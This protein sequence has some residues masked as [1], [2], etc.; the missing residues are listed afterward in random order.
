MRKINVS[1]LSLDEL[2]DLD[3]RVQAA[4]EAK[5]QEKIEELRT[6]VKEMAAEKG[7]NIN[8][9]I[10]TPSGRGRLKKATS[11]KGALP[12]K[13]RDPQTGKTWSGRGRP[14]FWM[15]RAVEL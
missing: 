9:L 13:Y 11:T 7:F 2:N 12:P 15:D 8:D 3:G 4:I 1:K 10:R 14:P 5:K 6:K